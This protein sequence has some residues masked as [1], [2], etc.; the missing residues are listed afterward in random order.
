[1]DNS[2]NLEIIYEDHEIVVINKPAGMLS[3]SGRGEEKLDS[4]EYR[5]KQV[6]PQA[7]A[8]H[9]LDM[10]T[11]GVLIIA[12]HKQA[13]RF[14][15]Q[16]FAERRVRKS[17]QAICHGLPEARSGKLTYP[18]ICDWPNRPRQ[19]V[20]YETGKAS[21]T[22]YRVL[23]T[24][25]GKTSRVHLIPHTGRSHQLRLH[26]ATLGNPIVGDGFYAYTE[27]AHLPRLLLHACRVKITNWQSKKLVFTSPCPF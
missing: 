5:V 12:K 17:Y 22:Y 1:M 27:D 2:L 11:S 3:V 8:V 15:K 21:L 14:Y 26:L 25:A 23:S 6:Y 9:R 13:E 10:A 16:A 24:E 7:M 20:C 19:K 4:V 18:L